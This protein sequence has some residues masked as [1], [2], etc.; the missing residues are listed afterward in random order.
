MG[1]EL[2]GGVC[3]RGMK[4]IARIFLLL[5]GDERM[6]GDNKNRRIWMDVGS[7]KSDR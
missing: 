5:L 6:A 4:G 2:R 3:T 1:L 7:W